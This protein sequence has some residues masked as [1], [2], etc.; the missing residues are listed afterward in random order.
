ML[1]DAGLTDL[2][3]EETMLGAA[4]KVVELSKAGK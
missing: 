2:H 4:A 3:V 1:G